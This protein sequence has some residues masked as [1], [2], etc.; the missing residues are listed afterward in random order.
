MLRP[1]GLRAA[2]VVSYPLVLCFAADLLGVKPRYGGDSD[3]IC[4]YVPFVRW[5]RLGVAGWTGR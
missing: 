1:T 2:L 4:N 5:S 3:F